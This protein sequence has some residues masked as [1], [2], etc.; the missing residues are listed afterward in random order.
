MNAFKEN[1]SKVGFDCQQ[2]QSLPK[3]SVWKFFIQEKFGWK[4]RQVGNV[5]K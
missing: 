3:M 1:T 5:T 4:R 2:N